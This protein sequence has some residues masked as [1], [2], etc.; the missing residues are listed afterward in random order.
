MKLIYFFKHLAIHSGNTSS[1]IY[2]WVP[3]VDAL[4]AVSSP[5]TTFWRWPWSPYIWP[6]PTGRPLVELVALC[7]ERQNSLPNYITNLKQ[8]IFYLLIRSS[9]NMKFVSLNLLQSLHSFVDHLV[10]LSIINS[11]YMV[12]DKSFFLANLY[13]SKFTSI[14]NTVVHTLAQ[15]DRVP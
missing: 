13:A 4:L 10:E 9:S 6:L 12:A 11:W 2:H 8:I 15:K 3:W 1:N 5:C 7:P 14:V